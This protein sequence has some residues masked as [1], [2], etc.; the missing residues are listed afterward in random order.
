MNR[1]HRW[2]GGNLRETN[3]PDLLRSGA[4]TSPNSV[5]PSLANTPKLKNV[6]GAQGFAFGQRGSGHDHPLTA[7]MNLSRIIIGFFVIT[8]T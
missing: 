1:S 8:G 2:L 7:S 3:A 6:V 4:L 5:I